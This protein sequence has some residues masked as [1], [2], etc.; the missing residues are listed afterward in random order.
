MR[1]GATALLLEN[2]APQE[3][4][5]AIEKYGVSVLFTAPTA[6]RALLRHDLTGKLGSLRRCVSAGEHLPESVWRRF[7]EET[8]LAIINGIGGTEMLH[9]FIS[10][11]DDDIRPGATGRPVPGFVA[12]IQ[13]EEGNPVADGSPGLLAV[14]GPIG[15]RYLADDRQRNYV[16]R[17]WNITGDIYVRDS[18]GYFWYQARS[19]DMIVSSGYNIA[20]PEV[21]E[22]INQHPDVIESTVVGLADEDRGMIVHAVVVLRDGVVGDHAKVK[23]LQDFVK[24]VAAPYKYPRSIAFIDHLPRTHNGKVQRFRVRPPSPDA[25]R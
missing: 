2:S 11:A 12:E 18:D 13:D 16:R 7:R 22:V 5:D 4:G 25:M 10:A 19:D 23:E 14:K 17:G 15:C 9:I 6:Y 20:A 1:V 8:G 3:L 21:E 24:G